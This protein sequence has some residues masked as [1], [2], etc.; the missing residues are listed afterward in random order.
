M[1]NIDGQIVF[2]MLLA[3]PLSAALGWWVAARY[4]K[5][6]LALMRGGAAHKS[7]AGCAPA[8]HARSEVNSD[9]DLACNR[10]MTRRLSQVLVAISLAIGLSLAW[11][12]LA[13]VYTEGGYGLRKLLVMGLLEAWPAVP[14]LGLLWRWSL[15][16][17]AAGVL[18]Y[19]LAITLLV[20]LSSNESQSALTVFGWLLGGAMV[21]LLALLSL[22]S[23]GRIRAVSPFLFP[24]CASLIA[25]SMLA[26][27]WLAVRVDTPPES[28]LVVVETIGALPAIALFALL[29]WLVAIWPVMGLARWLAGRYRAKRFSELGYLFGV[30]WLVVLIGRVLPATHSAIGLGAFA[31][32]MAWLWVPLGFVLARGW[33]TPPG[34][35][36]TLLVLRV[37]RRDAEVASLFDAVIERWRQSGNTVMIAGTD[38]VTHTVDPDDI[39]TFLSRR[40]GERFIASPADV[41]AR[42]AGF[43]LVADPDG[44]YRVNE[45]YCT[46]ATWQA[47]LDALVGQSHVVLMD[48]RGFA[49]ENA[50]CL[51]ELGALAA[52]PG[53]LRVVVLHDAQT[54]R[55]A[56]DE[57]IAAAPPGRFVW[58]E[59]AALDR[60][61]RERILAALLG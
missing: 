28:L 43:D 51:F 50:G 30:F 60:R 4:R 8:V 11:F 15:G 58:I 32:I 9:I 34:G 38:L 7:I 61:C 2:A 52:A 53:L 3:L 14:A 26:L 25:A 44:R 59:A 55:A 49:R 16:R 37:F 22:A 23:S 35:P 19:L 36:P 48:L 27:E 46:D 21:P 41:A 10:R 42:I 6:M 13:F 18:A 12:E 20:V 45:C 31:G 54:D 47:A 29:P 33:L 5:A 57:R 24:A 56:A 1:S 40:L 17:T 39:F